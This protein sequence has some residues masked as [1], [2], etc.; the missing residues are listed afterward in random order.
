MPVYNV[1]AR[2][3]IV[4]PLK[5]KAKSVSDAHRQA[6]G[7]LLGQTGWNEELDEKLKSIGVELDH[8]LPHQLWEFKVVGEGS[9]SSKMLH[10]KTKAKRKM[11]ARAT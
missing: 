6:V 5:I 11:S 10:K 4:Q 3:V 1:R 7:Q 8:I 9:K 2:F